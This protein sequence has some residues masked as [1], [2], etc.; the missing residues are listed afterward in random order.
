MI[1]LKCVDQ[2]YP[3]SNALLYI[4][5]L[6][7]NKGEFVGILGENGSGKTTLLKAILG[8]GELQDGEL[9]IEGKRVDE[10]FARM[11]FVTEEGSFLPNRTPIEY[12]RFLADFFP[13]FDRDY[14]ERLL[15]L[16]ELPVDRKIRTFSKGQKMK[17]EMSAGLAKRADYFLMDEPFVGKDV[18]SRRD[19][20]KQLMSGLKGG[21]TIVL[22]THQVDEIENAID[23]A[24]V[25]HK[26]L[27]RADVYIDE[28]RE[29]GKSLTDVMVEA[30]N[31]RSYG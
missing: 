11:A 18:F 23:R 10:Q 22:A 20:L 15:K 29:Q 7:I 16:Y 14:Y 19:S 8:I 12:A 4:R 17:L 9:A 3:I 5:G 6:T 24:L 26:G 30:R 1:E 2:R 21:E 25:I 13:D 28:L 31:L 27:V